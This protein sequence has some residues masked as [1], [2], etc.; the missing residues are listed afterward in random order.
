MPHPVPQWA[1]HTDV[2]AASLRFM[3]KQLEEGIDSFARA[4]SIDCGKP[5]KES[6]SD[7]GF[8]ASIFRYYADVAE[9]RM[10]TH[11][12]ETGDP[13]Y[14]AR[15]IPEPCGVVGCITPWN[16]PLMQA[17][18]KIAPALAAGCAV[19]VK[20][21][22]LASVTTLALGRLVSVQ[23]EECVCVCV[24]VWC[25]VVWCGAVWCVV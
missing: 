10:V 11:T 2:R 17:V 7:M 6:L 4:E 15:V 9:R 21:S 5:L 12:V 19:V 18:N 22:P 13:G 16:Y 8:C 14:T 25:A 3:A 23:L 1:N 24:C 20:P